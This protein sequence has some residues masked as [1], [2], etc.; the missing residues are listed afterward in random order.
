MEIQTVQ[1]KKL[2][3]NAMPLQYAHGVEDSG[4]DLYVAAI[5]VKENGEWKEY[6]EYN[7]KCGETVLVKTGWAVSLPIGTELQIR[8][9]SGNSLKTLI[10]IPNSPGTIDAGYRNEIGVIVHHIGGCHTDDINLEVG[11]KIAQ[12]V[13][14]PVLHADIIEVE[15]LDNSVRG[16]DGYGSTG[17]ILTT[18]NT[19]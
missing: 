13:L 18:G 12:A 7:L 14:C 3:D 17:T 4:M 19:K 1:A 16:L 8:P 9:T 5:A 10:R 2:R 6:D 15:E 11:Q